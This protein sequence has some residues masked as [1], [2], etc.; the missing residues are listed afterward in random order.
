MG[1]EPRGRAIGGGFVRATGTAGRSRVD[2][3]ASKN[4]PF[5]ISKWEVWQAYQ[6]VK[7]NKGAPGVDGC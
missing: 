3:Q 1:V 7:A 4:K 6:Q 5:A 2:H